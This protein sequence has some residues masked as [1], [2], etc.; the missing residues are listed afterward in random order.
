MTE[1]LNVDDIGPGPGTGNG[2]VAI[3]NLN[4][5]EVRV[6]FL[7]SLLD[8]IIGDVN[9]RRLLSYIRPVMAGPLLDIYRN[10]AVEWFLKECTAE[11]ML[12]IDSD[13][14]WTLEDFYHL[15]DSADPSDRP[16][17]AGTYL[18]ILPEGMRPSI[19]HRNASHTMTPWPA[20]DKLPID[21]LIEVDGT[22]AG[23]LLMHRSLLQ[24]MLQVYGAP[25]PWFANEVINGV[26]NGEDFT[27][28]SRVQQMG[29]KVYVHTG[30]QLNHTKM[31]TF[32]IDSWNV[33]PGNIR[34]SITQP[35][36]ATNASD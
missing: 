11:W 21:T 29:C 34:P 33:S 6:E 12:F 26:V 1:E 31:A 7:Q 24:A 13:I 10:R 5:G 3:V 8:T 14:I 17:V 20:D 16:V 32:N 9:S 15:I 36:G 30:V 27:F 2:K 28:C 22:G 19:F 18:M 25:M 4:P 35:I 23:F